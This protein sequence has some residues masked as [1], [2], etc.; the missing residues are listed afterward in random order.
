MKVTAKRPQVIASIF[1]LLAT[2]VAAVWGARL[3]PL[4][5]KNPSQPAPQRLATRTGYPDRI[6]AS[7][8][9]PG[10]RVLLDRLGDR[11][12]KRGRERLVLVGTLN[13]AGASQPV[14]VV[15]EFPNLLRVAGRNGV[16]LSFNARSA[17]DRQAIPGDGKSLVESLFYDSAECFFVAQVRGAATRFLGPRANI[18]GSNG[19]NLYDIYEVTDEDAAR[20]PGQ[21]RTKRYFFNSDTQLL[22]IVRYDVER[23]GGAISVET[24]FTGWRDVESQRVPGN[25][26]RFENG[27]LVFSFAIT[28]TMAGPRESTNKPIPQGNPT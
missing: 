6:L 3:L 11:L 8:L 12:S 17:E 10:V 14:E 28:S 24:R 15:H 18:E 21:P 4:R 19:G 23:N 26:A 27:K 25:V 22:E 20:G 5:D 9:R 2:G 16:L 13:R 1:L 7:R